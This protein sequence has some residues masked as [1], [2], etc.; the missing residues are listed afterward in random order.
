MWTI[1]AHKYAGN[2]NILAGREVCDYLL[3]FS[4]L[5]L[6]IFVRYFSFNTEKT[7]IDPQSHSETK[8]V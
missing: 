3:V 4:P 2:V 1:P 7:T 8:G 5:N 6:F